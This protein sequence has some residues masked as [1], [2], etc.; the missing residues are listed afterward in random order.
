NQAP[1]NGH[2]NR[3]RADVVRAFL[4]TL[5]IDVDIAQEER[6][7]RAQIEAG[8]P[9]PGLYD[10]RLRRCE[11][12]RAVI[13]PYA[14]G[15]HRAS[16]LLEGEIRTAFR[17]SASREEQHELVAC[18]AAIE[19]RPSEREATAALLKRADSSEWSGGHGGGS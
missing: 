16:P 5:E 17:A 15:T 1:P 7:R 9:N 10:R 19:A 12:A 11:R 13:A 18:V 8:L 14:A 4:S 6:A 2:P 3:L